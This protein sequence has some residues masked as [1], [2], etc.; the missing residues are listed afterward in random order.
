M[1]EEPF[2]RR[3]AAGVLDVAF[4]DAGPADGIPTILLHGFPYDAHAYDEVATDL[5]ASLLAIP[6]MQI[7]SAAGAA[8]GY[9]VPTI[10]L[11]G[12]DDGVDPP[13]VADKDAVH[14]T[15]RYARLVLRVWATTSRR[16][17]RRNLQTR[18]ES[19]GE[20]VERLCD[21][22]LPTAAVP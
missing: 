21:R 11:L 6:P 14:F 10:V 1:V 5:A 22:L 18:S 13:P 20:W 8:A 12:A 15:G 19:L 9:F 4:Y 3:V 17:C 2:L 7:S 16:K